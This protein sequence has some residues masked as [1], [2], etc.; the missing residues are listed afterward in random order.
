MI[1][2]LKWVYFK[3]KNKGKKRRIFLKAKNWFYVLKFLKLT[4]KNYLKINPLINCPEFLSFRN[5]TILN[6]TVKYMQDEET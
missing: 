6:L 2:N 4:T 3:T 5:I 1:K